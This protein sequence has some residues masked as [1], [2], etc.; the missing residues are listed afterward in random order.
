MQRGGRTVKERLRAN[1]VD[2]RLGELRSE[3]ADVRRKLL[4]KPL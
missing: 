1:A 4:A 3:V 2:A